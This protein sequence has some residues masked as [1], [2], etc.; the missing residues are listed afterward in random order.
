MIWIIKFLEIQRT[1]NVKKACLPK[2]ES[3]PLSALIITYIVFSVYRVLSFYN[4]GCSIV[5]KNILQQGLKTCAVF[6]G[7][8]IGC[9]LVFLLD[10]HHDT[11]RYLYFQNSYMM[12]DFSFLHPTLSIQNNEK[13]GF[14]PSTVYCL[15]EKF[16]FEQN[17]HALN[18]SLGNID[19][20]FSQLYGYLSVVGTSV[21]LAHSST[22]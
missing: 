14:L 20:V 15:V 5:N 11:F 17:A 10:F 7:L 4:F 1:I 13:K 6:N 9:N 3:I 19:H 21:L 16:D 12:F 8:P 2:K 18:S 22:K